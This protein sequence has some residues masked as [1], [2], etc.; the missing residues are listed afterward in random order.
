M[1]DTTRLVGPDCTWWVR[2]RGV[3]AG[4]PSDMQPADPLSPT[5]AC[6]GDRSGQNPRGLRTV[7]G[8][9]PQAASVQQRWRQTAANGDTQQQPANSG[10]YF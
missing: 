8:R 3:L 1:S 5:A 9:R 2:L 4:R 6:A 7:C 10:R